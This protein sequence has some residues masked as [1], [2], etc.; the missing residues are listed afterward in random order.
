MAKWLSKACSHHA[1]SYKR[2]LGEAIVH[3]N[4]AVTPAQMAQ[5][6]ERGIPISSNQIGLQFDDGSSNPVLGF[7]E[8]R[9]VDM[10]DVWNAQKTSRAKLDK[11]NN[12]V[13]SS[14]D[15]A[16]LPRQ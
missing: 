3:P 2:H 9:Y 15:E 6:T 13:A 11:L 1:I 12:H 16:A 14:S 7:E 4:L 8:R 10:A 5:L